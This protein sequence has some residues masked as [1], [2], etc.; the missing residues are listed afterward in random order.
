MFCLYHIRWNSK[1]KSIFICFAS[2][3]LNKTLNLDQSFYILP[4]LEFVTMNL[5]MIFIHFSSIKF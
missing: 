4:L 2:I 1:L 3:K 5:H